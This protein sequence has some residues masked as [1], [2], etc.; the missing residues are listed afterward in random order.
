M[1]ALD[2]L[3]GLLAAHADLWPEDARVHLHRARQA[4]DAVGLPCPEEHCAVVPDHS[5]LRTLAGVARGELAAHP[6]LLAAVCALVGACEEL[7][8]WGPPVLP[9]RA[10][11][12]AWREARDGL[13]LDREAGL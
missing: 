10:L 1:G 9:T 11:L 5:T 3:L 8:W 2:T 4:A 7:A 12:A 13:V 6:E